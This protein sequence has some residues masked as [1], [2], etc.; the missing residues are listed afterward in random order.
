MR[1]DPGAI[2]RRDAIESCLPKKPEPTAEAK[3]TSRA[4]GEP[5]QALTTDELNK[6]VAYADATGDMSRLDEVDNFRQTLTPELQAE[7]DQQLEALRNDPRIE[8]QYEDGLPQSA[9]MEDLALRGTLAATFGNPDL[10]DRTLDD[11]ANADGKVPFI[12]HDGPVPIDAYYPGAEAGSTAAGLA[13]PD[14]GIAID[15]GF[16]RGATA[17]G[18]NPFVHEFSHLT[19]RVP[20][21]GQEAESGQ[22][23][24][25]DFPYT[26]GVEEAF[27]EPGFQDYL[28]DRFF[29]GNRPTDDAGNPVDLVHQGAETWP[30]LQNLFHQYPEELQQNSPEIYRSM[31]E[32]FGYDPLTQTSSAPV[33]LNGTGSVAQ[34]TEALRTNFGDL[35]TEDGKI[36]TDTLERLLADNDPS[37]PQDVRA[38]AAFLLSSPVSR[39]AL[40]VGAGKGKVDGII[41]LEDL[42]GMDEAL[43]GGG[44]LYDLLGD[45]AAGRGGRDDHVSEDDLRALLEDPGVP[46]E[47]RLQA[48]VALAL[49][50]LQQ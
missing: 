48:Q 35:P 34:A 42:E 30:T 17:R 6:V 22:R 41:S 49:R 50:A 12:F 32:Y 29:G 13:L 7:Y 11:S 9:A 44:N 43:A 46:P 36:S 15:D 1:K 23:F 47:V 37:I 20:Q 25:G 31:S 21:P 45:T 24:P 40:D 14:G 26:D 39:N 33:Q 18:D 2:F 10:L 5:F 28:V 4:P 3:G 38:A 27:N 16:M 8:F 19:Q